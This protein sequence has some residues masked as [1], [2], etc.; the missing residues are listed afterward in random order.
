MEACKFDSG[1]NK[2]VPGVKVTKQETNSSYSFGESGNQTFLKKTKGKESNLTRTLKK[3]GV[4][5][6]LSQSQ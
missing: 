6:K 3:L 5:T 1:S 2:N 4:L